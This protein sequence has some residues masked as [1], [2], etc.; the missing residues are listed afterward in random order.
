L[1]RRAG[2]VRGDDRMAASYFMNTFNVVIDD[3]M[4]RNAAQK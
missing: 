2:F 1:I 3:T 4:L